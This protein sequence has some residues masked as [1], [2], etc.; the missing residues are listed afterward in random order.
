[1]REEDPLVQQ[2]MAGFWPALGVVDP[3]RIQAGTAR[4]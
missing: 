3:V 1:M 4:D 2:A